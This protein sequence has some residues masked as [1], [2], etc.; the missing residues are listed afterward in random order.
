MSSIFRQVA[1]SLSNWCN[2]LF[3][4][5]LQ[6]VCNECLHLLRTIEIAIEALIKRRSVDVSEQDRVYVKVEEDEEEGTEWKK[7]SEP[8]EAD[9]AM[10]AEAE[11]AVERDG[12]NYWK[13]EH[14]NLN[15]EEEEEEEVENEVEETEETM[16]DDDDAPITINITEETDGSVVPRVDAGET[17]KRNLYSYHSK[18]GVNKVEDENLL[19]CLKVSI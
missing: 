13:E 17:R 6:M 19:K 1:R 14:E 5:I 18:D 12:I 11:I 8:T 10:R 3:V 7:G 15:W 9:D 16:N 4:F 2:V